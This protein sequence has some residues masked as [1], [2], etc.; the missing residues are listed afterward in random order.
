ML[1]VDGVAVLVI[2]LM[3]VLIGLAMCFVMKSYMRCRS[4]VVCGTA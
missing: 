3:P 1:S 4:A 2:L